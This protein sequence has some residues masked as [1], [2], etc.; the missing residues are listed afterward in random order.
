MRAIMCELLQKIFPLWV[1]NTCV[2]Q[3]RAEVNITIIKDRIFCHEIR[4]NAGDTIPSCYYNTILMSANRVATNSCFHGREILQNSLCM[5]ITII[6]SPRWL[7]LSDQ[8]S[9]IERSY[10]YNDMTVNLHVWEAGATQCVARLIN[11]LAIRWL[12]RHLICKCKR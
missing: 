3:K 9:K 10:I 2:Y 1:S 12:T 5:L 4:S 7:I 8:R 11:E 6:Q